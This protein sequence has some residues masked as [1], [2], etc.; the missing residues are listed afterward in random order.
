MGFLML[1][2]I[3]RKRSRKLFGAYGEARMNTFIMIQPQ[4][5]DLHKV[6]EEAIA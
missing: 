5:L 2:I 3:M 6:I 4:S 1:I